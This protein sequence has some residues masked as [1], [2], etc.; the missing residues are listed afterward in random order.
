MYKIAGH[1]P[2]TVTKM[3]LS[4]LKDDSKDVRLS[5]YMEFFRKPGNEKKFS[6]TY[7]ILS[8]LFFNDLDLFPRLVHNK[9]HVFFDLTIRPYVN[10]EVEQYGAPGFYVSRKPHPVLY[11]FCVF[12]QCKDRMEAFLKCLEFSEEYL[13]L[14]EVAKTKVSKIISASMGLNFQRF[15]ED[16]DYSFSKFISIF[17]YLAEVRQ[18]FE[19]L[20]EQIYHT[21]F[22]Y[23][24]LQTPMIVLE[25]RGFAY[26]E[27]FNDVSKNL[28]LYMLM[29]LVKYSHTRLQVYLENISDLVLYFIQMVRYKSIRQIDK[30]KVFR[31]LV[32]FTNESLFSEKIRLNCRMIMS[33]VSV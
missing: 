28:P 11:R 14:G 31:V 2:K 29:F 16:P 23:I 33:H 8:C 30:Q 4:R 20:Q 7:F 24:L 32:P 6:D 10:G 27:E 18:P 25:A 3:F 9:R 17:D 13:S 19:N 26:V 5:A 1:T 12:L 22:T 21:A 15:H